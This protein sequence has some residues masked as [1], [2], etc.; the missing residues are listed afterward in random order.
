MK[1]WRWLVAVHERELETLAVAAV[2][3]GVL[4]AFTGACICLM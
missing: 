3:A 1:R 4:A 2:L